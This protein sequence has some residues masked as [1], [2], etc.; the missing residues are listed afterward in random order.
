MAKRAPAEIFS[1]IVVL[2][3]YNWDI[4]KYKK[5]KCIN[6]RIIE[7]IDTAYSLISIKTINSYFSWVS[8]FSLDTTSKSSQM[9]KS[10]N[11]QTKKARYIVITFL[12]DMSFFF[13]WNDDED[14]GLMTWYSIAYLTPT[15]HY[16]YKV[17][18]NM[19]FIFAHNLFWVNDPR[20]W[21]EHL[22]ERHQ[23]LQYETCNEAIIR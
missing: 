7:I 12:H 19:F 4:T 3:I 6:I 5:I 10:K 16:F 14:H 17:Q 8:V 22:R 21:R 11:I 18:T 2:W 23:C 1:I 9:Y 15:K 13:V 20:N